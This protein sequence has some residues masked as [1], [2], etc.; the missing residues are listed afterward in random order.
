[1][2]PP[3]TVST[4]SSY[5][6]RSASLGR[7]IQP[8]REAAAVELEVQRRRLADTAPAARH[9]HRRLRAGD[10]LDVHVRLRGLESYARAK[11]ML[12]FQYVGQYSLPSVALTFVKRTSLPVVRS[13]RY[14]SQPLP[15]S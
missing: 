11:P 12:P 6:A 15:F 9:A 14:T 3:P 2:S 13:S 7:Y 8:K 5:F 4:R 10:V 1:M